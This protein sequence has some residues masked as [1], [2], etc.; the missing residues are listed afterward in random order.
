MFWEVGGILIL[1]FIQGSRMPRPLPHVTSTYLVA[2]KVTLDINI[3]LAYGDRGWRKVRVV[4]NEPGLEVT[5]ITSAHI[6]L[7]RIRL[8][9]LDWY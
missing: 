5:Y 7:A 9:A 2:S 8:P 6:P 4:L 1:A 3:Q